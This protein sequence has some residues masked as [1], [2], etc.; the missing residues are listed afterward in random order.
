LQGRHRRRRT[1]LTL[2]VENKVDAVEG[3]R[4]CDTLFERFSGA[5]FVFL[6]PTGRAPQTATGAAAPA[7]SVVRYC[8]LRTILE[9]ALLDSVS[10]GPGRRVTEDYLRTLK[11]EFP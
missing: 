2:V 5:R 3:W 9:R 1:G 8:D 11:K 7:F 4:Q 6:T 10:D